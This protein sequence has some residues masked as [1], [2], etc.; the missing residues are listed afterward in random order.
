MSSRLCQGDG[1]V[2]RPFRRAHRQGSLDRDS[3]FVRPEYVALVAQRYGSD[4]L[5]W[6]KRLVVI[7]VPWYCRDAG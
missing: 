6:L 5:S 3:L 1:Y 2:A 7:C 4:F